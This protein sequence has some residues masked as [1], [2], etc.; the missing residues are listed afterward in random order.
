MRTQQ[1]SPD[2][3]NTQSN[4]DDNNN[5]NHNNSNNNRKRHPSLLRSSSHNL[6]AL[7]SDSLRNLRLTKWTNTLFVHFCN[8]VAPCHSCMPGRTLCHTQCEHPGGNEESRNISHCKDIIPLMSFPVTNINITIPDVRKL[9]R[10]HRIFQAKEI[11]VCQ[12]LPQK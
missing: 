11:R 6:F 9:C 7:W 3:K 2:T 5:N 1:P 12:N 10:D 8:A 4:N